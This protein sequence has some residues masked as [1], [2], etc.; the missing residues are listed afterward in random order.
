M[1]YSD[2]VPWKPEAKLIE[3]C[4][5]SLPHHEKLTWVRIIYERWSC[6]FFFLIP[7]MNQCG[8]QK[9]LL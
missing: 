3:V 8:K 1:S 7:S 6:D 4:V 9:H 2:D 5:I